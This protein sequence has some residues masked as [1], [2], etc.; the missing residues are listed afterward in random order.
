MAGS[1]QRA[2]PLILIGDDEM[3]RFLQR[4]YWEPAGFDIVEAKSGAA[5]LQLFAECKP[6]LVLDAGGAVD[7][8]ATVAPVIRS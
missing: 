7:D 5:A 2:K 8:G 1:L 3:E 4:G 6:D